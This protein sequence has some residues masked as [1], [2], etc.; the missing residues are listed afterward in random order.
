[1]S[2]VLGTVDPAQSVTDR[3]AVHCSCP[4]SKLAE[5]TV[6]RPAATAR[7]GPAEN[8]RG[9]VCGS[10][11]S[12]LTDAIMAMTSRPRPSM[13]DSVRRFVRIAVMRSTLIDGS[14]CSWSTQP[15]PRAEGDRSLSKPVPRQALKRPLVS[16]LLYAASAYAASLQST[17]ATAFTQPQRTDT[18][19]Q[20][21]ARWWYSRGRPP[22]PAA[23]SMRRP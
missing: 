14:H 2:A 23:S 13:I 16:L 20:L 3:T 11:R 15:S 19:N 4:V 12:A 18:R 8:P 5:P 9:N 21:G 6:M 10:G 22:S 7:R 1:V 17:R